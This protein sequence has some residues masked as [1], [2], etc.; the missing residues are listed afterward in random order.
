[1][2]YNYLTD[3]VG[4][5]RSV[6]GGV[7]KAEMPGL[8]FV[9]A[10]LGR[11]GL[12]NLV[13]SGSPPVVNQDTTA[14]FK[15]SVSPP[16]YAAEGVLY[17]WN[18]A[19]Y[20]PATPELF[21]TMLINS[22]TVGT[23][24]T[25]Y[26]VTG[27]PSNTIGVNGD[28][29]LRIDAPGG[30]YGP[31]AAGMWPAD[32]LPGT[33]YSQI[34][35]FLDFLGTVQGD[36]VYRGA[37]SW[38]VLAPG[39]S[40]Q[41]LQSGG[42]AANPSWENTSGIVSAG[43]DDIGNVQGDI[44]YRNATVWTVLAPGTSGQFLETGGAGA[45]PSWASPSAFTLN[46][47]AVDAAFGA[48]AG[49]VLV[50]GA[51]W[52]NSGA[53]SAGQVL[54]SNGATAPTFQTPVVSSALLDTAFGGVQGSVLYRNATVWTALAPGVNGQFLQTGGPAANPSWQTASAPLFGGAIGSYALSNATQGVDPAGVIYPGTW[55]QVSIAPGLG[56]PA[57]YLVQRIA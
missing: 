12:I 21:I 54:T 18:G 10:A 29:A 52:A 28:Y 49:G 43:L 1:M 45:N 34:S 30:I 53:G 26:A 56:P 55:Q 20:V 19:A 15:P 31:K 17:L 48:T 44:L 50:R 14:W 6:T 24:L 3:F 22:M 23:F 4:L 2:A 13:I 36:I 37:S 46:S 7:E 11:A 40:G 51:G 39:T 47:A 32:P 25:I 16:D 41:V 38:E 57:V 42:P 35:S 9:V 33:S 8:D 5:W 27:V